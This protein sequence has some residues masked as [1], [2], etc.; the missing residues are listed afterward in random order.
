MARQLDRLDGFLGR[1]VFRTVGLLCGVIALVCGYA[2]WWQVQNWSLDYGWV[3]VI[4]FGL[5]AI[6][7]ASV[8]PFCFSR[9]RRLVEALDAMEDEVPGPP[10][11]P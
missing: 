1:L 7:A 3:P 5:A 10:R 11:R 6:A 9:N 8:I 2:A 4:L